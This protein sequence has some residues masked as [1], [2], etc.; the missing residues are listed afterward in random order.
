[1]SA[2]DWAE[3][4]WHCDAIIHNGA[5]VNFLYPYER[6]RPANVAG[7]IETLHLASEG[8]PKALHFVSTL[9]VLMSGGYGPGRTVGEEDELDHSDGLPSGY[10][11]SKWVADRLVT[12]AMARG[13]TGS[14]YRLGMLSGLMETGTYHKVNEFLPSFLKGC[15][16]LGAFPDLD[17]KIEMVPVDFVC[18]VLA[19]VIR[20]PA[21]LGRVYQMNHPAALPARAVVETIRQYG[22][23][24]RLLAWEPWKR[25]LLGLGRALRDNA[26]YPF[27]DFIRPLHENQTFM[28]E[29]RMTNFLAA[30]ERQ[31]LSCAPQDVLMRRY[32]DHFVTIGFL[33]APA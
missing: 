16:Q 2:P 21:G 30:V 29:M 20:D 28:P 1:L 15:V 12:A 9:G 19:A 4:A 8:R 22:Y 33:P 31:G 23:P 17:T 11:Q 25:E 24:L 27:L 5:W 18:R 26:L 7:T 10:E 3:V 6:L 13:L 32:L 14:V